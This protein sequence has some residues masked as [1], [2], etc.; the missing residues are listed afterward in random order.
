MKG[1]M[2][3]FL[4]ICF[5]FLI[6][7][8]SFAEISLEVC[9]AIKNLSTTCQEIEDRLTVEEMKEEIDKL[10][11]EH[12]LEQVRNGIFEPAPQPIVIQVVPVAQKE[13]DVKIITYFEED[14]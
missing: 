11:T 3:Y 2:K 14:K 13:E 6:Q 12:R 4:L 10:E 8:A 9:Y 7:T 1:I 5:V